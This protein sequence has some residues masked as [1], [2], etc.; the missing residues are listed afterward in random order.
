MKKLFVMAMMAATSIIMTG[1]GSKNSATIYP[2]TMVIT[3]VDYESDTVSATTATGYI[4]EF[5]GTE[6]WYVGDLAGMIMDD[7]GTPEITDDKILQVR[8]VGYTELFDM[9]ELEAVEHMYE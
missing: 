2:A 9:Q 7:N 4:Y 1:C 8:Y 5:Y 6:D 3:S